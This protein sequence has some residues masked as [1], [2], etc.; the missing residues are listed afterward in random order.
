[1]AKAVPCLAQ[2]AVTRCSGWRG[3]VQHR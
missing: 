1:M 2:G 3:M